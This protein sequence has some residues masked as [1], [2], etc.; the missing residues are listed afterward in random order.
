MR[1][2]AKL[3][4]YFGAKCV[5]FEE[6]NIF[7]SPRL[8]ATLH[9]RGEEGDLNLDEVRNPTNAILIMLLGVEGTN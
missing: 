4:A 3:W 8:Y 5:K 9:K 6:K 1:P 2:N 7:Q